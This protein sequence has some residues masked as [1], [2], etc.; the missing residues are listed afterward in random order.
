MQ[1][2]QPL[3]NCFGVAGYIGVG[4][5]AVHACHCRQRLLCSVVL[6][7]E[8]HKALGLLH[9]RASQGAL[10]LLN[11]VGVRA[12][13]LRCFDAVGWAAGRASGLYKKLSGG[14]L[15]WLS[16]WSEVQTCTWPS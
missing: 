3:R 6:F 5:P 9:H 4:P 16:P 10:K 8:Q 13:G 1:Q 14:V 11:S 15:A 12:V 2:L 7:V